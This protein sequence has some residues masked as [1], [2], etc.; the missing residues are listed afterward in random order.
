MN[1]DSVLGLPCFVSSTAPRHQKSE[2]NPNT[3]F[4]YSIIQ[5]H[6]LYNPRDGTPCSALRG[7]RLSSERTKRQ[8]LNASRTA[9]RIE[10][11]RVNSRRTAHESIHS[12]AFLRCR[13][14]AR[15]EETFA[16]EPRRLEACETLRRSLGLRSTPNRRASRIPIR[17]G[18]TFGREGGDS[19][20]DRSSCR[21][22]GRRERTIS[23]S[24]CPRSRR[25]VGSPEQALA[26]APP[27]CRC[28]AFDRPNCGKVDTCAHHIYLHQVACGSM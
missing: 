14:T 8:A 19:T 15:R 7:R 2:S 16:D 11:R 23:A 1:I 10:R 20:E 3:V 12:R 28:L 21:H 13:Q 6:S 22:P 17:D 18:R 26:R 4:V 27:S 5:P 9:A 25:H 24:R